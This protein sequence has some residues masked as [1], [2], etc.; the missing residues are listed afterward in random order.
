M[1]VKRLIL[2]ATAMV[3]VSAPLT[4]A[5]G[6]TRAD[7]IPLGQSATSG[8]VCQA[9]RDYDD[10][11][12]QAAGRRAW[13]I[14]CRGWE[15]SLGRIYAFD[16]AAD[17]SAWEAALPAR[18]QCADTKTQD[19]GALA[20]VS[21]RACRSVRGSAPYVTYAARKGAGA[22][23]AEGP[24]Q[25]A[26]VLETGLKIA[27]GTVKAPAAAAVQTSA[28]SA[29]I[30]ADFGGAAGGLARSQAAASTDPARLRARAYV[31][32]NEWRFDEAETDFQALVAD[33]EARRAPPAE[34]AEAI[35]N[36][37]LNVSNNG[38]F[39]EADRLFRDAETQVAA[40]DDPLLAAQSR[41]YRALH[42]RN[43]GR[44]AEAV[45]A[46]RAALRASNQ[47][48][49]QRG[50]A[51]GGATVLQT[52]NGDL[53]IT[54]DL[55]SALN[56]RGGGRDVMGAPRIS[57]ADR[58]AVQDAQALEVVGSSLAAQ[59]DDAG[60][61]EALLQAS[62]TLAAAETNGA[63]NVWLRARIEADLA[64]LDL[65]AGQAATAVG[66]YQNAVRILRLRHAG[67][68]TEGGLM[69][70]LGRAQ[71]AAGQEDAALTT[72]ARAFELFQEQRGALGASADDAA[73]YFDLLLKR[74]AAEPARADDYKA[75]FFNAASSV[76][77]NATAQTVSKLAARVASGDTAVTGL[78][79]A[80]DDTR[81]EL[82]A[83]EAQMA[84][85]QA[86]NAAAADRTDLEARLKT[87][88]VQ[89][90]GLEAQL[91]A[92]NPRYAQLVSSQAS[93]ADLQKVLGKDEVYVKLLL[94]NNRG[95]GML[96]SSTAAKPYVI[97]MGRGEA[98]AAVVALRRPFQA[99][100]TLPPFDVAR[101]HQVFQKL[102][103]PV[104]GD[105]MAAKHLVYEPDGALISLPVSTLVTADPA[106]L[107][108]KAAKGQDPDYRQ[109]AWLGAKTD[110]ALVLSAASF[111]QSRAFAPSRAA[112]PFL[113]FADPATPARND[114]RAYAGMMLRRSVSL[115]S[116]RDIS[117]VCE[118]TR[119]ALMQMPALPDT[120]DEVRAVGASLGATDPSQIVIGQA[121]TD[122]SVKDRKD[123][124]DY[125]VLYFATHGLLPQ[126]SACLP[127]PALMTSV[128]VGDS[129]G[130]L[131]ASEIL[132]LKLDADLVV[133]SACDTG[134]SG[135]DA[136]T[137]GMQGGGEALGGLT[138]AV[139]YAGGRSLI[140]SHWSVDSVATVRLMTGMFSAG[141]P[142]KAEALG[143]AQRTLI[144]SEQFSHPYYWA[145]FT[146]V[147]DGSKPL[148][149]AAPRA[150][151]D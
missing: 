116:N 147:G 69:L 141:A 47:V 56:R 76:V 43:A 148:P 78:V 143:Q 144:A 14:R 112:R 2:A 27:A 52:G 118:N 28:A 111:M 33:A 150:A 71:V 123:L 45:D 87:L 94:L 120:A 106:A 15:G 102:F 70:D 50:L 37:A 89:A 35:L 51:T 80:L 6:Q 86:A 9:V 113:A 38:R 59:G 90:D 103:G 88:Q 145:P 40:A 149:A 109:V 108:A 129:D 4:G 11:V 42:L 119:L 81:R 29:E 117:N 93:L 63:L 67:T 135:G 128:G 100:D 8:A 17:A 85:A 114:S 13:N 16:K 99:E 96:V 64:D 91:L 132:D 115:R 83:A 53:A 22:Y 20:G 39:V 36:L 75:R 60:A 68:A 134:G 110:S 95:Y 125:K 57:L 122:E 30:A 131:D 54:G 73:P 107:L 7:L 72:Y 92:A 10:P 18:A 137:T 151:A 146:I 31:Q 65:D 105:V 101:S 124:S 46:G 41:T 136:T 32:N 142:S 77:S 25:I 62:R 127:E 130:L 55:A 48:R 23:A 121:F 74:I 97:D 19:L 21:R 3:A 133:L 24:A 138:R 5:I 1:T 26:D 104:A 82:R 66:R 79:R 98:G 44:F 58:L 34:M 139:I 12:V 140:V 49:G 84:N 61:R 126:P